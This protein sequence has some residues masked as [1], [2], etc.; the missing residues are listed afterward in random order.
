[1]NTLAYKPENI[2]CH[3]PVNSDTTWSVTDEW[4]TLSNNF[5]DRQAEWLSPLAQT[6]CDGHACCP[7]VP[8]SNKLFF[9]SNFTI[10]TD[11]T[12]LYEVIT[13]DL[14]VVKIWKNMDPAQSVLTTPQGKGASGSVV[15]QKG[16]YS[17][18]IEAIDVNNTATGAV[19]AL[20]SN[21]GG[22]IKHTLGNDNWCIFQV[23]ASE[24]AE[25]FVPAV[26]A[27]LKCFGRP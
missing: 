27:C 10:A 5:K 4:K 2:L 23:T 16:Q 3:I 12:Y 6:S 14:G 26:A 17:V 13:D 20:R 7:F 21:Q 1:M 25:T 18:I 15:L 9:V 8:N 19:F 24:V 22:V 11:D